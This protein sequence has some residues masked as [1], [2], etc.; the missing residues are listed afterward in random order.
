M[1]K[2][3]GNGPRTPI[4]YLPI[5]LQV[6]EFESKSLLAATL[7]R[8]VYSV[9]LGQQWMLYANLGRLP[10]GVFLFKSLNK[11]HHPA[12]AEARRA[13]HRVVI[14]EEELLAQTGE[15]PV[16]SICAEG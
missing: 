9:V 1:S 2:H 7:A 8:Q 5:E 14:L 3:S 15:M 4:V 12:M 10:P 11:I 16:V 13:G 6:R